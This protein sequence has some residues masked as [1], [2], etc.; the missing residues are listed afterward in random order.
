[1]SQKLVAVDIE[2]AEA[3]RQVE[4]KPQDE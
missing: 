1:M 2:R 4:K 3:A